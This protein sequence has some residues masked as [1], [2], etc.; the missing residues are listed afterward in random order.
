MPLPLP[1]SLV[2]WYCFVV[3]NQHCTPNVFFF[4][5]VTEFRK[6]DSS[7]LVSPEGS[8]RVPF[9][10]TQKPRF[11]VLKS[12]PTP[13]SIT[14]KPAG[15]TNATTSLKSKKIMPQKRPLAADFF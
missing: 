15:N 5:V 10:P 11:G 6:T 7:L 4:C 1:W 2:T 3:R 14:K 9:D 12:S 8:S 13:V